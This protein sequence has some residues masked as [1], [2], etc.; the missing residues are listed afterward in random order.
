MPPFE[1]MTTRCERFEYSK[2]RDARSEYDFFLCS[3][4]MRYDKDGL[5]HLCSFVCICVSFAFIR[6]VYHAGLDQP[7]SVVFLCHLSHHADT[8]HL[9]VQMPEKERKIQE[10]GMCT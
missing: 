4:W 7:E 8:Q 10:Q 6:T 9:D 1:R 5:Y 2:G 3:L